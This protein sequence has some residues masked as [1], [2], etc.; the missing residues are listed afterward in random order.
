M[1]NNI[2]VVQTTI[3][4]KKPNKNKIVINANNHQRP[5]K[6]IPLLLI[7]VWIYFDYWSEE[8]ENTVIIKL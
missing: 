5:I 3:A 7:S 4:P 6:S 1:K 2:T 8:T